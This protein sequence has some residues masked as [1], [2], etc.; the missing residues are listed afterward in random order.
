M[1]AFSVAVPAWV[2][3]RRSHSRS[4]LPRMHDLGSRADPIRRD[5]TLRRTTHR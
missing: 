3:A 2:L 4:R 1:V 5:G